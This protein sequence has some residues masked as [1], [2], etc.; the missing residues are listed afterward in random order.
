MKLLTENDI[1]ESGFSHVFVSSTDLTVKVDVED[2]RVTQTRDMDKIEIDGTLRV[3]LTG[4]QVGKDTTFVLGGNILIIKDDL[5]ITLRKYEFTGDKENFM[6]K[7]FDETF[8]KLTAK[9]LH[10]KLDTN[11]AE[12]LTDSKNIVRGYMTSLL[13]SNQMLFSLQLQ[14]GMMDS[15]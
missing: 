1:R 3:S 13:S 6:I 9:T 5:Y 10:K 14:K 7:D 12:S 15:S 8:G 11:I 2:Y 4:S